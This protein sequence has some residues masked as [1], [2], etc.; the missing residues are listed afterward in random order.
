MNSFF[1]NP[2]SHL[3]YQNALAELADGVISPLTED[4]LS[5]T[6]LP[7]DVVDPYVSRTM[8]AR[9][10]M[11][12]TYSSLSVWTEEAKKANYFTK[13]FVT[14]SRMINT[15]VATMARGLAT[16]HAFGEDL[17]DAPMSI[18]DLIMLASYHFRKSYLGVLQ[19][20]R[21]HPEIGERLLMNQLSW[22]DTLMRLFKTKDKLSK[23]AA[24]VKKNTEIEVSGSTDPS[25]LQAPEKKGLPDADVRPMDGF[26]AVAAP[27][28]YGAVRAYAPISSNQKSDER[29]GQ[30][31]N[32]E[33]EQVVE[34]EEAQVPVEEAASAD[35]SDEGKEEAADSKTS[36]TGGNGP[37]MDDVPVSSGD[38]VLPCAEDPPEYYRILYKATCRSME[39]GE[40]GLTFTEE[41]V[42]ELLADPE[43][44]R[45][46]R[47]TASYLRKLLLGVEQESA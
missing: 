3:M 8:E 6:P 31:G 12:L 46:E 43:F 27:T 1:D 13:H 15:G 7:N 4:V 41:E 45:R 22:A 9:S 34:P 19:T 18:Q 30:A 10:T 40:E 29:C 20:S 17:S 21:S 33:E 28:A 23:K 2:V 44:C 42:R 37:A 16:L 14:L 38:G 24:V 47:G 39:S 36:V 5:Y 11:E 26:S 25:E 35:V 32:P